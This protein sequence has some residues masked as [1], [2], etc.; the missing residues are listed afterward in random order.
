MIKARELE[1][2]PESAPRGDS[3]ANGSVEN[4]VRVTVAQIR[5]LKDALDHRLGKR[6][7]SDAPVLLWLIIYAGILL[8]RF[9]VG[10]D[11]LTPYRRIKG[12]R[13]SKPVAEFGE[14]IYWRKNKDEHKNLTNHVPTSKLR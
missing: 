7:P 5:T 13:C 3:K 2:I 1:T 14:H 10:S 6:V 12:K 11:G 8:S 4:A 9:G